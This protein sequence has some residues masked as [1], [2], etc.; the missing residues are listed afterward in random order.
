M[1][2]GSINAAGAALRFFFEVTLE[3]PGLVRHLAPVQRRARRRWSDVARNTAG[4]AAMGAERRRA[5]VGAT[6]QKA[7]RAVRR[8][9]AEAPELPMLAKCPSGIH[10]LDVITEGG[11]P[12]GRPTLVCG[13][14]G[15]G[16]T[17]FGLQFLIHGIL[18][19]DEPGVFMCFEERQQDLAANVASLGF[20]L[21]ALIAARK[22]V[23][24]QVTIDRQEITEIGEYSLDG[25]FIRLGAA[26]DEVGA[27]RV[28][29]DTI[30]V[31][32]GALSNLG[33]LRSELRRLFLW[34]KEKGV[35]TI[36]TGERGGGALTRQGL[37][38]Y[39]SDCVI[40]LDQRVTD[41]IATRR[42]RIVKYRGS[43]HGSN[44]YPFL[45]D[46]QGFSVLPITAI[47]LNYPVS[48]EQISTGIPKLDAMLGGAGYFRGGS[49]LVSGTAGTGKT[50]IA[51]HFVDAA[52]QRGER[53]VYFAFEESPDQ[54]VRN[55]RSIGIDLGQ[56]RAK[57]LLRLHASRPSSFGLEVHLGSMLR[58]IDQFQPQ[59]VILDP[60]SSF[61]LAG[62]HLD[63]KAML[64]RMIDL[65]KSRQITALFTSLTAGGHAVEQS[66]VGISSLIDT[67][68]MLRNLE[69]SGERSRTLSV[70]KS[71]G[72]KHSNQVRELLLS[73]K[74][75][76]LAEVFIGRDGQIL[77]GSARSA[78]MMADRAEAA[79]LMQD[80]SRNKAALLRKRTAIEAKI[81]ELQAELTAETAEIGLAI[82]QQEATAASLATDRAAL[83]RERTDGGDAQPRRANGGAR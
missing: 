54:L 50:S 36:V 48:R 58:L 46:Q 65:L 24:D 12:R 64:M 34:L 59:V 55:M 69:Q 6:A 4:V 25:L 38:E 62:A 33:I 56:W 71:R 20:D 14:S 60:A 28:V 63:A 47:G 18:D 15:C 31:L 9:G 10:G 5:R 2:P 21:P 79:A 37:E 77:T 74:G 8:E 16:K 75:V 29:L 39:V 3:R 61:D 81:A 19:N 80:V 51:A 11:L 73:D 76:D 26:I 35:T 17:L 52:C 43:A 42:L 72:V 27:K 57:D 70:I 78:N 53:C 40:L 41:Q 82:T 22:L 32:F 68:L 7:V 83:A 49:L 66:E 30:E 44:E 23:V 45:L 67:W 13:A 1:D